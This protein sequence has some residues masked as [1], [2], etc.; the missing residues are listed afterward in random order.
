MLHFGAGMLQMI[1]CL[2]GVKSIRLQK[3]DYERLLIFVFFVQF[4]DF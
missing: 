2:F 1:F 3:K 4:A